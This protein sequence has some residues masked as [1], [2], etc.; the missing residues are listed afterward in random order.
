MI[1]TT[2]TV[3]TDGL[4]RTAEQLDRRLRAA[5]RKTAY[6]IEGDAKDRVPVDTGFL[7]RSIYSVTDRGSGY[8]GGGDVLPARQRPPGISAVVAV[9]APYG[10]FV[11][12]GHHGRSGQPYMTPAIERNREPFIQAIKDAVE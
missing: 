7:R 2:V 8:P 6:D 12:Y 10:V 11:E 4:H 9:A 5:V 1:T 3:N